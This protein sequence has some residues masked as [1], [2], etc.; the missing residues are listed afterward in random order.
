MA[1][2]IFE[3]VARN[4]LIKSVKSIFLAGISL[5][6]VNNIHIRIRCKLCLKLTIKTPELRQ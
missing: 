1:C 5:L 4:L 3:K 2:E 6:E